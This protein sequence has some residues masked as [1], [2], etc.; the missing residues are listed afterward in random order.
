MKLASPGWGAKRIAVELGYSRNTV[1]RYLRQGGWQPYRQPK[2]CRHLQGLEGWLEERLLRHR[3][4][5]D[6][7]RQDLQREQRIAVSWCGGE[8]S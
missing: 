6:V 4:N 5:A 3:G 7:V 1:R 8:A 2:R